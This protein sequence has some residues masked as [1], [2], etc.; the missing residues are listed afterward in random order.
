MGAM[1]K[2]HSCLFLIFLLVATGCAPS[3]SYYISVN[4]QSSDEAIAYYTS[5]LT[6]AS[7]GMHRDAI[8][9]FRKAVAADPF[10]AEPYLSLSKSYYAINN[11]DLAVFYNIKH[12]ELE[13]ARDYAYNYRLDVD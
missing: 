6:L 1:R 13:V 8:D 7:Q 4:P 12:Y 5:G 2:V 10:F 3:Q 9:Q 11:Y